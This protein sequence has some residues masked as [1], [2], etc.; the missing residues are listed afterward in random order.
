MGEGH[1]LQKGVDR[2]AAFG[3]GHAGFLQKCRPLQHRLPGR[4]GHVADTDLD[5]HILQGLVRAVPGKV[6]QQRGFQ[7]F[8]RLGFRLRL[9]CRGSLRR[10]EQPD[11]QRCIALP[12]TGQKICLFP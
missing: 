1:T 12:L 6:F 10:G 3:P 11:D 7:R 9:G 5:R 8:V 4:M 2:R